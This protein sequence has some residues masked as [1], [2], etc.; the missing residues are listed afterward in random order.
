MKYTFNFWNNDHLE[1]F[2]KI[3]KYFMEENTRYCRFLE[4][5]TFEGRTAIWL[6]ENILKEVHNERYPQLTIVDPDP[7]PNFKENMNEWIDW[8][9]KGWHI[10]KRDFVRLKKLYSFNMLT[11]MIR[12]GYKFDF[13]YID[14]DHNACGILED[15]VLSW[16]LLSKNGILLFDDYLMKVEDPWFYISHKEFNDK[17]VW[18]HPKHAIDSFLSIYKGQYE[19]F[20]DNYQIGIKKICQIGGKNLYHN[21][22][23]LN[24][25]LKRTNKI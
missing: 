20:I 11:S 21:N 6:I 19:M 12:Q 17:L 22:P 13:I 14:G 15:A 16:H 2:T 23:E 8:T 24:T 5:G 10:N 1:N 18:Q 9:E 4:I 3:Q 25:K 7:A